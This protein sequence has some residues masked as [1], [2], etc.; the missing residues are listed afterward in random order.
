MNA[1]RIRPQPPPALAE[2]NVDQ[3]EAAWN[4]GERPTI[5]A[6]LPSEGDQLATLVVLVHIDLERRLKANEAVRVESYLE[7]YPRLAEDRDVVLGLLEAEYLLRRRNEPALN[8]DEYCQRF[9]EYT[10]QLRKRI[11]EWDMEMFKRAVLM[12]PKPGGRLAAQGEAGGPCLPAAAAAWTPDR[13]EA[14]LRQAGGSRPKGIKGS[15]EDSRV[16]GYQRTLRMYRLHRKP[17]RG[18]AADC[19]VFAPADVR[20]GEEV[21]VQ[22]FTF[23]VGQEA[24][25]AERA[26]EFDEEA[27]RRGFA[28]LKVL[29]CRGDVLQFHLSFRGI[30]VED[31]VRELTWQGRTASVQFVVGIPADRPPGNLI[32]TIIVSKEGVPVGHIGFKLTVISGGQRQDTREAVSV[33]EAASRFRKAFV[34]YASQDR[35]EVLKRVQMLRPPMTD[36]KVFQDVL[37]LEPGEQFEPILFRRIDECDIFLLFWSSNAQRSEWVHKEIEY[38]RRRQGPGG[39]P[40]PTI[41]PVI[42]EG[43]PPPK[44]PPELAHLHFNDY[45]LYLAR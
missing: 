43:P 27:I 7:R 10:E 26:K 31:P 36:I 5:E 15:G 24:E 4:R 35:P 22:A 3:F 13:V 20:Q 16:R 12:R 6:Y 1:R 34:S 11:A 2:Q 25:P 29:L 45:L 38:A 40:P 23:P 44:P 37:A 21:L 14:M 30:T 9:P 33:G 42:I 18:K 32:G 19:A 28:T 17:R 8:A 39:H 41:L